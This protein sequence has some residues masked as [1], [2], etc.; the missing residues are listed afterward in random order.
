MS[1]NGTG[2]VEVFYNGLWGTIC[3]DYWDKNDADVACRQLGYAN[4]VRALQ[5]GRVPDGI[6]KIW[7]DDVRC[8]GN[9]RSLFDCS[10]SGWG[11]HNCRHSED[12]GVECSKA[13]K[14]TFKNKSKLL[15]HRYICGYNMHC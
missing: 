6:G 8:I 13:G 5:G 1:A 12:A 14:M 9:E 3:D 2:R 10:H 7:L 15:C 11:R 4:A